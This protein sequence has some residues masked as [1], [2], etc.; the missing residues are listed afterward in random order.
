MAEHIG[1]IDLKSLPDLLSE[2]RKCIRQA[3]RALH[4]QSIELATGNAGSEIVMVRLI[5]E[6]HVL[7]RK[8]S[9]LVSNM[10]RKLSEGDTMGE[11]ADA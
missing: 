11:K 1:Q 5:S 10:E 2:Q 7:L 6:A 8:L 9:G 3:H 4:E